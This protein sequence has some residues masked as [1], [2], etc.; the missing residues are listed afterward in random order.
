MSNTDEKVIAK[1]A[2]VAKEQKLADPRIIA[3]DKDTGRA[4]SQRFHWYLN[5]SFV[6]DRKPEELETISERETK[7]LGLK[8]CSVCDRRK[9]GG[10]AIEVLEGFFGEDWPYMNPDP[11]GGLAYDPRDVA[12]KLQEYLKGHN[13]Y[14]AVRSAKG[15]S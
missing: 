8:V 12:W 14:L 2:D 15:S 4:E 6:K 5:C 13:V 9:S 11:V 10:K 7:L 1:L 3:I